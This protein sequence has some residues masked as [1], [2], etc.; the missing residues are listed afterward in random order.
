[1]G[2]VDVGVVAARWVMWGCGV[3][4]CG[5]LGCVMVGM[6]VVVGLSSG[7]SV[8][9]GPDLCVRCVLRVGPRC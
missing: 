8:V 1:M 6:S 3:V 9:L 5:C 4:A 7:L 2:L